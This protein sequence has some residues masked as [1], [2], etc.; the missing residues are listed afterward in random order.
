LCLACS[1]L[2]NLGLVGQAAAQQ[3]QATPSTLSARIAAAKSG[4]T[5]VLA[6]GSYGPLNIGNRKFSGAGLV[7]EPRPGAKAV[8]TS[9][10]V[11]NSQGMTLKGLEVDIQSELFGVGVYNSDHIILTGLNIHAPPG[12][13]F[14]GMMLRNSTYVTV[15]DSKLSLVGTG[16]NFIDSDHVEILRNS[17][18]DV[19]SDSIRGAS[20]HVD[21]IGNHATN[22][23]PQPGDH[24]DFIQFWSTKE[25]GPSTGNRI[26]DNV[27]ERGAG[28]P[29]QG[30]FIGD[31]KDIVISGNA[32][33][34]TMVNAIALAEVQG[35]LVED[36]FVQGYA[37]QGAKIIT[38]GRSAD[39]TIRNNVS[40]RVE[41]YA[42]DGANTGYKE[43]GN[44]LIGTAKPGDTSAMQA[45]LAKK[46]QK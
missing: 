19:Q 4:E 32:L 9:I 28:D 16:I 5:I 46:D 27:Y 39:V 21:V 24:P 14:N 22:F 1:A 15:A 18:T 31:N 36:N 29:V 7:I 41:N 43:Q 23:H 25:T 35:A 20:S 30:V 6:P 33:F 45:W 2:A 38:R 40:P 37:D 10:A 42:G 12:K 26:K 11:A 44:R 3:T 34:G 8:F 17:L 13:E